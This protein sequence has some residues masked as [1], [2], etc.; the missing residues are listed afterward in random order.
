[1]QEIVAFTKPVSLNHPPSPIGNNLAYPNALVPER[2]RK[3]VVRHRQHD[4]L[5][6]RTGCGS[7]FVTGDMGFG[8][9]GAAA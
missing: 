5:H 6:Y 2:L 3:L 8:A 9:S 4:G 1:V 7:G